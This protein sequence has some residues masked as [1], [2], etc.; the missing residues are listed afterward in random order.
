MPK[1]PG[2]NN[3]LLYSKIEIKRISK[4]EVFRILVRLP[5]VE[6]GYLILPWV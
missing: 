6:A 3:I 2:K 5:G 4:K 1:T